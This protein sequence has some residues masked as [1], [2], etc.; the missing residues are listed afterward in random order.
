MDWLEERLAKLPTA[1]GVYLM[2]DRQGEVVY[3]GKAVNLKSRVRSYFN[4][5]GD[6][7]AFIPLLE[8]LLGEIET[9]VVASEKEALLLENELIKRHKPRFNVQLRD[10]KNF[11]CLRLDPR[12]DY[13]RLE[14]VRSFKNDGARYFGPYASA[15]SIRETLRII[16]RYFQLRT[17]SDHVLANRKR[18]CLLFQIGR[19]PA[20]CVNPIPRADYHR[21][22]EAVTLF[23]E[24]KASALVEDLRVRIK[25]AAGELRFEDA[26][27]LRDQLFAIERSLERQRIAVTEAIDQDVFAYYREGERLLF[28]VLYVRQGRISGGQAFPFSGQEFPTEEL[29]DSFASLYY[30]HENLVPDQVLLPL[31]LEG[32]TEALE[33]VLTERKGARVRVLIPKRGDRHE[34]IALAKKNAEQAFVDRRH[35]REE[36]DAILARLQTRLHLSKLPW[37]M[38]CYDISHFQGSAIVASQVAVT[39][40]EVDKARYRR[41]KIKSVTG[42][43]DFASMHEVLTRRLKGGLHAGDLPDLIVVDGGKGQLASAHAAMKDLGIEGIDLV[44]LAKSRDEDTPEDRTSKTQKSNERVFLLHRKDPIVLAQNSAELFMLTRMR[45]EA[46]RFAI[47]FQQKLMRGRNFRSV[48]EDIPGVGEGRKKSLLKAFGSL[49]RVREA[50]IEQLTD[51]VG[52]SLAERIHGSLHGEPPDLEEEAV[53][54]DGS[55]EDAVA[56]SAPPNSHSP[57]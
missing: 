21:N 29:L 43:D 10:D 4:R 9:V 40:G 42:Q 7:R 15:S 24:G 5:T 18:P 20:P 25:H 1:P 37:R 44:G 33:Q 3:V 46:H 23:L 49:K 38:E 45:D 35:S 41:F 50:T 32:G 55:L 26:A 30:D 13:P 52:P 36:T 2:K 56:E 11:I 51:V 54:R 53:V 19:C 39:G 14:V 22:V 6:P 27:R 8:G 47:T 34:L 16:N 31:A 48:L 12:P 28:Y 57:E 17:C